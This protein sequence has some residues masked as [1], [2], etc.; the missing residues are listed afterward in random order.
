MP[1]K[2]LVSFLA[3]TV[4][5]DLNDEGTPLHQVIGDL[6]RDERAVGKQGDEEALLLGVSV[7]V[8]EIFAREDLSPREEKPQAACLR[9]FVE[10]AAMLVV[11]Q[12]PA[13]RLQVAH[14]EVVVTVD[15]LQGAAA[16][17]LDGGIGGD[18]LGQYLAVQIAR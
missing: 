12:L 14:G 18:A 15:A 9:H 10:D 5:G 6:G 13:F 2:P 8:E 1:V 17:D 16:S 7:N 3:A 11:G 4:E